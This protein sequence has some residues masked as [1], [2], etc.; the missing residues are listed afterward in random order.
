LAKAGVITR[1][2]TAKPS[3]K[4]RHIAIGFGLLRASSRVSH[5]P[6][7]SSIRDATRHKFNDNAHFDSS[8]DGHLSALEHCV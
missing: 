2:L 3:T 5:P 1:A 4:A 7:E 6:S 8:A